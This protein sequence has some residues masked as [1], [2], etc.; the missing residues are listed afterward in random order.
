[1]TAG[2]RTPALACAAALALTGCIAT[3]SQPRGAAHLAAMR[4]ATRHYHHGRYEEAARAWA[5]AARTAERRVD[6]EEAEYRRARTLLDLD[7]DREA[8]SIL[9]AIARRRPISRRT[10]RARFD[11]ALIRLEL[12]EIE[13]ACAALRWIVTEHPEAGPASRSL[14]LLME[15]RRDEPAGARLAFLRDLYARVGASDLGDDVL[16]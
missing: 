12:G 11:A 13:A 10:V 8:L 7:R 16:W 6:R 5:E 15:A 3:L 1:M 14:R 9:D 4:E 2:A